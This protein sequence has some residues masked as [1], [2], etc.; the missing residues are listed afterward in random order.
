MTALVEP[1]VISQIGIRIL[2]PTSWGCIELIRKGADG[3]RDGKVFR[4]EKRKLAL[5]IKTSRRDPRV[6]Q[7]VKCDV[8]QD[9]I[10]REALT[11]AVKDACDEF[12]A[13]C[14][15]IKHPGCEAHR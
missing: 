13:A 15:V 12:V 2:C 10:S 6:R 4:G 14:I 3:N 5:P 1:V 9:V 11:P 8:V 7:P